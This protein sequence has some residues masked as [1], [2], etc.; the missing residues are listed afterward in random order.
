MLPEDLAKEVANS[1]WVGDLP[2]YEVLKF[3]DGSAE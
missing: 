2:K 3:V 1:A